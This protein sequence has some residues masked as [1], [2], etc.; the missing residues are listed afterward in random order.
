[1]VANK[2]KKHLNKVIIP[3]YCDKLIIKNRW[4][5]WVLIIYLK[6]SFTYNE[7]EELVNETNSLNKRGIML[8]YGE[9]TY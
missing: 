5:M 9:A 7:L 3:Y 2:R 4:N 1:M 6:N 8:G